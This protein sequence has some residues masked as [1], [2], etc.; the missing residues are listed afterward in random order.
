MAAVII[1]SFCFLL[2]NGLHDASSVVATFVACG[3]ATP[4]QAVLW[5]ASWE[6]LGALVGGSAVAQ[7][8]AQL[9]LV[10]VDHHLLLILLAALLAAML[11]NLITWRL[12]LPSSSTHALVGGL[13]GAVW[14]ASG[15]EYIAW[16]WSNLTGS[17][18]ELTGIVKVVL[19]LLISPVLGFFVAFYLHRC[20]AFALRNATFAANKHLK[21][22]QWLITGLL[23]YSHGSNDTQKVIALITLALAAYSGTAVAAEIPLWVKAS[24]GMVMF[25]G[26][27]FG[28]WSIIKTLGS[29][30][31]TL[32]PIHSFNSQVAAGGS[33]L[34]ATLAGAPVSTTHLVAGSVIGVGAADEYRMVNWQ[35]GKEMLVA[36]CVTIPASASVAAATYLLISWIIR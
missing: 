14:L 6:L 10:P 30:I 19:S 23:A 28:G 8:I 1:A 5:A 13:I 32:R 9:L 3:A 18:H 17:G 2:T 35:V 36:W 33:L 20:M 34:A 26:I 7:T 27:M 29:G 11:W 4:L 24:G 22:G 21:R 15:I 25:L 16:G 31:F 12:G